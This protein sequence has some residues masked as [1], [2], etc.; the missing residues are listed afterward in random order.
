[1]KNRRNFV[2]QALAGAGFLGLSLF[3]KKAEASEL[4]ITIG[5]GFVHHVFFW[6]KNPDSKAD[7][8]RFE[9]GINLLLTIPEIKLSHVGKPVQSPREVVDDSF[10]YSY[11][12]IFENE[13]DQDSY[14]VHP[15]HLK[16]VEEYGDLWQKVIVYDA[17]N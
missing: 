8:K 2:K 4:K 7:C 6:L 3:A 14:Q 5:K 13:A 1:M 11:M 9:E 16:F 10:T 17:M 15:T 12:A